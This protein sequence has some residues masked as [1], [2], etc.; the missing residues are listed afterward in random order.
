V[1]LLTSMNIHKGVEE[2]THEN[3]QFD[4]Q[5]E[6]ESYQHVFCMQVL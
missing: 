5:Q 2:R 6:F 1:G 4:F 3:F